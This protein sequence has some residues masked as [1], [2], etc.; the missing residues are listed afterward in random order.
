[1]SIKEIAKSVGVSASTVSRVLN[2]SEYRCAD[3][4]LRDKI[5]KK[6]MELN[7][8]PNEAARQLKTGHD[9]GEHRTFYINILMTKTDET[10][11]DPFFSELLRVIESEIH[12]HYCILTRI[13][14]QPIFSDDKKCRR[15]NLQSYI[16]ELYQETEEKNDGLIIIGRCSQ[17][18]LH[19]WNKKYKNI[20]SVNR[21]STNYEVDEVICDGEKI[22]KIVLD[23]LF[24]LGHTEIAY[25]GDC[26]NE[27]RYRGFLRNMD[28]QGAEVE[29]DWII[30]THPSETDG[31]EAMKRI[32]KMEHKPTAI[33]CANDITAVGILKCLNRYKGRYYTPSVIASDDIEAAQNTKPMLT[34][35]RLPKEEMGRFAVY[36]LLDRIQGGH[37][38]NIKLELEGKL[39]LRNSCSLAADS[40]WSDYCI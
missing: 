11:T 12:K 23:Y 38:S 25:V 40:M 3:P 30:D 7:Y 27:A 39:M 14:Y 26:H 35:V 24:S 1:M 34:T 16:D 36:L 31:Y 22:S 8:T 19:I 20:V 18:A 33:Y 17:E 13:W 10:Q 6:A 29:H 21:N 9:T 2:H 5:W 4:T 15:M 32:L 37:K 28:K